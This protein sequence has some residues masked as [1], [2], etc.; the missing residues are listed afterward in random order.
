MTAKE[1]QSWQYDNENDNKNNNMAT[2]NRTDKIT[3]KWR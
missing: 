2:M 1:E 3:K